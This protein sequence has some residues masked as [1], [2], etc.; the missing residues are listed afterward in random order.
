MYPLR[1][2]YILI[3]LV[4]VMQYCSLKKT[5]ETDV[6]HAVTHFRNIPGS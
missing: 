4:N 2:Q 1:L 5:W 6:E 3:Y